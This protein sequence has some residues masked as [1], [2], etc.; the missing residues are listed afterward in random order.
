[1]A[2]FSV[3]VVVLPLWLLKRK[4]AKREKEKPKNA[5]KGMIAFFSILLVRRSGLK[6]VFFFEVLMGKFYL[7]STFIIS[8]T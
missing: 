6:H 7:T 5:E 4:R 2:A 3:A 1:M 8:A